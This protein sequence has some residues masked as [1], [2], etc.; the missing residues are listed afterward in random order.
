LL[1]GPNL[2]TVQGVNRSGLR[3]TNVVDTITITNSNSGAPLPVLINE[4]MADN[5]GPFGF[6]D[7]ADGLFQDWFELFNPNTNAVNLAGF[8]LTDNLG[9]P[10]KWQIPLGAVIA[11]HGFLL[12]WADNQPAQNA[13]SAN[14]DLHAG[15]QLDSDGEV[16]GL[17]TPGVVAQHI[18]VFGQQIEN[19]S[20]GLFPDGNTNTLYF[21]TNWTPRA[22]N[23]L[24][25]PLRIMEITFNAGVVTLTWSAVPD[26][27]YQVEFKDNLEAPAWTPIGGPVSAVD[28]TASAT[29]SLPPNTRRFYRIL[30]LD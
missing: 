16:I 21:M 6:P 30:R 20:Q 4:W 23:T 1:N 18:I 8:Y 24:A 15:F 14:G 5:A 27:T 10:T 9:Q 28:V 26:R 17:F 13:T 3:P 22:A 29:D 25:G 12:V 11:P 2:L 7:P 19:V